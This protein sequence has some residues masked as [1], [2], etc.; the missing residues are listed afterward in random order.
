MTFE[1]GA[2]TDSRGGDMYNLV[3]SDARANSAV[4]YLIQQGVDPDRI[5]AKGFGETPW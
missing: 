4:N 3:L 5:A 1:L 2:H